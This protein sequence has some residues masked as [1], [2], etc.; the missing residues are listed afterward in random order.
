MA[1]IAVVV[2]LVVA[3]WKGAEERFPGPRPSI[4]VGG[5]ILREFGDYLGE[6]EALMGTLSGRGAREVLRTYDWKTWVAQAMALKE[7]EGLEGFV[8]LLEDVEALY[9][10]IE[11]CEG[12]FREEQIDWIRQV[13]S[14]KRLRERIREAIR[15]RR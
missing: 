12:E 9:W 5:T 14:E 2:L 15:W 13:I 3:P 4:K 11:A 8:P 1:A 10:E 6:C 7:R